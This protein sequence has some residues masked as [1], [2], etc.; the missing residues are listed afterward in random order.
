MYLV[1]AKNWTIVED[2]G[3]LKLEMWF[4]NFE[5]QQYKQL[6]TFTGYNVYG[7]IDEKIKSTYYKAFVKLNGLRVE[8]FTRNEGW[9][10]ET[11]GC[12]I[13]IMFETQ[14][15]HAFYFTRSIEEIE[16]LFKKYK[17]LNN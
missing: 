3:I 15:Q 4:N 5:T 13:T 14:I 1:F 9:Y 12:Q 8:K 6:L 7:L 16:N 17:M 11:N 2:N 10:I